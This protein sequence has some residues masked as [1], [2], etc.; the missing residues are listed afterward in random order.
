MC[1]ICG[2]FNI[3]GKPSSEREVRQMM[4]AIRHRGPDD[5]GVFIKDNIG[6]GHLRLSIID[7]SKAGHQP[8][9]DKSGRYCIVCNGELYN[10]I[11]LKEEL[12]D[13]YSFASMTDTEVILYAYAEWG[14]GC[15]ERFNGMFAF[16]IYD[17]Y[18][19]EVFIARDRFG[20]KP[21]YYY[22]DKNSFI[23][24]SEIKGILPILPGEREPNDKV[25]FDYLI[26]NRTDHITETF[27]KNIKRLEHGYCA[28]ISKDGIDFRQWY[29]I[30]KNTQAPFK[31]AEE[32]RNIMIDAV[33]V[34]LRSD[35]P[36]G[37]CLSGGIDSS[38][39]TSIL[40]KV[41]QKRDL[42][43][44]SAVY[45]GYDCDESR[46]INLYSDSVFK[47]H[48][49]CP[50]ARTLFNDMQDFIECHGEPLPS[51]SPYAQFKVMQLAKGN[52]KV[53]LDGQGADELFMGYHYFFSI[54]FKELL[55]N[56]K[57][58]RFFNEISCYCRKHRSFYAIRA[59]LFYLLPG[60]FKQE[61]KF[62][63]RRYLK[64]QFFRDQCGSSRIPDMLFSAHSLME[65]SLQHFSH[66]L[67]HILKWEDRNSMR[68]SLEARVPFL[69]HR[70][71]EGVLSLP[72]DQLIRCGSTK[73]ILREA[74]KDILPEEIRMRQDKIGFL[75][76]EDIWFR[77]PLF[78][79]FILEM[80]KSPS[81]LSSPYLDDELCLGL[82]KKHL[83]DQVNISRD[84]W[85]WINL[86]LWYNLFIQKGK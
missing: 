50:S 27:F 46:Y 59:F 36:V 83:R 74:M 9:F 57:L 22:S 71:V 56:L 21:L 51:T 84:I 30:S 77:E 68:F 23:F 54:Y 38:S 42:Q 45:E 20:I 12:K 78:K 31:S 26:Y 18:K 79:N 55:I 64:Q 44:F 3:D 80:L 24:A 52:V 37:V 35:V 2:I 72:S 8:M 43:T 19:K 34:H 62:L 65:A 67:E 14:R 40:T 1:G 29:D 60:Y 66:K 81:F 7:L 69:D 32:L 17:I 48:N 28:Y 58:F 25:I 13:K 75:T 82:Y 41:L 33:R 6:L 86:G 16:A 85:K 15:L 70:L 11:E 4:S 49:I 76:P 10:Y 61:A 5:E 63:G 73:F 39:I 53:L 47:M